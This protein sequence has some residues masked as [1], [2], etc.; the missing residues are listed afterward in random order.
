MIKTKE[1]IWWNRNPCHETNS[2]TGKD[3]IYD[4]AF[5]CMEEYAEQEAKA[6]AMYVIINGW[7]WRNLLQKFERIYLGT[8]AEASISDLYEIFKNNPTT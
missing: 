7:E 5:L 6:F 3:M 2:S 8:I 4:T 1:E